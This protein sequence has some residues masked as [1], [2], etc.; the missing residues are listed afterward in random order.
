MTTTPPKALGQ[1]G[2]NTKL[3]GWQTRPGDTTTVPPPEQS[4]DAA[5]DAGIGSAD[6]RHGSGGDGAHANGGAS[7]DAADR[8]D[9]ST[10]RPRTPLLRPTGGG[11]TVVMTG[12]G[13]EGLNFRT[14]LP[15]SAAATSG[16]R[17][18]LG[19]SGV[20]QVF[21]SPSSGMYTTP[22]SL[23][24]K[25]LKG[26]IGVPKPHAGSFQEAV[27]GVSGRKGEVL[28]LT[29][30]PYQAKPSNQGKL[31]KQKQHMPNRQANQSSKDSSQDSSRRAQTQHT[32]IKQP[33][34][35]IVPGSRR[36]LARL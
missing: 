28:A 3:V 2:V 31:F 33:M 35:P 14:P 26:S 11:G 36:S 6:I 19:P 10:Q 34:K 9:Q 15:A 4:Y 21:P 5:V 27:G 22:P 20:H 25:P 30:W 7:A 18:G 23:A 24:S 12:A 29:A 17:R 1:L 32:A 16:Y 8:L 13:G